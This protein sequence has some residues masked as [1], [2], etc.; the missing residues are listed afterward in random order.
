MCSV[1]GRENSMLE[2]YVISNQAFFRSRTFC[3]YRPRASGV[4]HSHPPSATLALR[5][6]LKKK[7]AVL[8]NMY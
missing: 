3:P 6:L 5:E 4:V 7:N 1:L 8:V 2:N